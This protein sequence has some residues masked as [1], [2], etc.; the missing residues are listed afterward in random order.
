M[1]SRENEI[2]LGV[3][4]LV[5][6]RKYYGAYFSKT[7]GGDYEKDL[8]LW[9]IY[10]ANGATH[11]LL[12]E[13]L[14]LEKRPVAR[15]VDNLIRKDLAYRDLNPENRKYRIVRLT[16]SGLERAMLISAAFRELD[17]TLLGA[18]SPSE[19]EY[20]HSAIS[21]MEEK[22]ATLSQTAFTLVMRIKG[23]NPVAENA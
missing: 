20:L 21:K 9:I 14:G 3:E 18:I 12:A 10:N 6:C 5:L 23:E 13:R 7:G 19:E 1:E 8:L 22:T 4:L 16:D 2:P 11:D 17:L 15:L